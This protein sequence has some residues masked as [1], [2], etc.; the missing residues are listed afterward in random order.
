MSV[1]S[2]TLVY[3]GLREEPDDAVDWQ[4]VEDAGPADEDVRPR[5]SAAAPA[6]AAPPAPVLP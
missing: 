1:W 5:S 4:V 6:P 3:L 2:R